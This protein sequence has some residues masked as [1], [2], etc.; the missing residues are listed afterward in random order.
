MLFN[1][2]LCMGRT[3]RCDGLLLPGNAAAQADPGPPPPES[4]VVPDKDMQVQEDDGVF[5]KVPAATG[6]S[7]QLLDFKQ[8]AKQT[9]RYGHLPATD[10]YIP[11]SCTLPSMYV[12]SAAIALLHHKLKSQ[13]TDEKQLCRP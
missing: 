2:S 13:H 9:L 8:I 12:H 6:Y 1:F 3:E 5:T 7:Y 10:C 4:D 11:H